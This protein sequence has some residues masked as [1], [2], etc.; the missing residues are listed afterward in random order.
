MAQQRGSGRAGRRLRLAVLVPV[1][2]VVGGLVACEP[3]PPSAA[4]EVVLHLD[5]ATSPDGTAQSTFRSSGSAAVRAQVVTADGGRARSRA[6]RAGGRAVRLP[7]FDPTS[8]APRA[9]MSI[10]NAGSTDPLDP[11]SAPFEFGADFALDATS[12]QTGSGSIDDGDNL[13]Q[14]GLWNDRSQFK[15]EIDGRRPACLVRGAAGTVTVVATTRVD[16]SRWYRV[17]CRREGGTVTLTLTRWSSD[18]SPVAQSW[19]ATGPTGD[20]TPASASV[21]LSVGGKLS[22]GAVDGHADQFNGSVDE[23]VLSID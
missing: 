21:P 13:I 20:L 2:A 12:A 8:P 4:P 19:S 17:R 5:D 3:T 9:I 6:G 7:A 15:V 16:A 11:N 23:V 1:V 10:T 18:G 14:R 22:G